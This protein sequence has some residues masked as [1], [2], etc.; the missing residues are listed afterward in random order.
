MNALLQHVHS[1]C[2]CQA[3]SIPWLRSTFTYVHINL[4]DWEFKH[5]KSAGKMNCRL[6]VW[7]AAHAAPGAVKA[8]FLQPFLYWNYPQRVKAAGL[9]YQPSK[10]MLSMFHQGTQHNAISGAII[11]TYTKPE[12]E[13]FRTG[14]VILAG[15]FP[16]AGQFAG[17]VRFSMS[18][19]SAYIPD[20]LE[21]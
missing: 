3:M 10:S 4:S 15:V 16:L 21:S 20:A 13:Q 11:I 7:H 12:M 1:R 19:M 17:S 8:M 6:W 9:S 18:C 5:C 14:P 2:C